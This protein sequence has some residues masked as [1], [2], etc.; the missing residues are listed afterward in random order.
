MTH[1][2][3]IS[4]R[5]QMLD[6]IPRRTYATHGFDRYPAKMIPHL[7][8]WIIEKYTEVGEI[9]LD[10]FCGCGTVLVESRVSGRQADGIDINPYAV[11]LAK[12]KSGLYRKQALKNA[13]TQVVDTAT[14]YNNSTNKVPTWLQYWY[15]PAT[16]R[17]LQYLRKSIE[18]CERKV[19]P[20]YI[21]AL[22][23]ILGVTAR[24]SSKADP[25]SPKPFISKKARRERCGR[26]F[27]AIKIYQYYGNKFV[28]AA[29]EFRSL[30]LDSRTVR[31]RALVDD[32]RNL[33]NMENQ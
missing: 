33:T 27:D 11:L 5:E 17:K 8:R 3:T 4:V 26:H 16:L 23:A 10:P 6:V 20:E 14:T 18:A 22:K 19:S 12:A 13:I 1:P 25:R 31:V 7:A 29:D 2:K 28:N 32:A 30:V 15:S 24:M 21:P 9:I